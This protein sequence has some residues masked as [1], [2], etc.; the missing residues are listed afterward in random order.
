MPT[1]EVRIYETV[2]HT[3]TVEADNKEQ[4]YEKGYEIIANG[5][6]DGYDTEAEG[7]TDDWEVWEIVPLS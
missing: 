5:P 6:T 7:F 3:A 4:A 2:F 1:W